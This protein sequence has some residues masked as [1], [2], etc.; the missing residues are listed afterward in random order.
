[1]Y[2]GKCGAYI[3]DGYEFCMKCGTKIDVSQIEVD[4]TSKTEVTQIDESSEKEDKHIENTEV[5]EVDSDKKQN[6]SKR[7]KPIIIVGVITILILIGIFAMRCT[8]EK[9]GYFLN[10]PWGT[11]LEDV[12][13]KVIKKYN[14]ETRIEDQCVIAAIKDYEGMKDVTI[15]PY[16]YCEKNG[17]LHTVLA[18]ISPENGSSYT[19]EQAGEKLIEKYIDL[20]GDAESPR[21][22]SYKWTTKNSVIELT[23][24]GDNSIFLSYEEKQ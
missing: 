17:T 6:I 15:L 10:I 16:F 7:L 11:E 12:Q 24:I 23:Y 13:E 8:N 19:V 22:G 4:K 1:M 18:I 2:C 21:T 5:G 20:F 3:P 9:D 14:A